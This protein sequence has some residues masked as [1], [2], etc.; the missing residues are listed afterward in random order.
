M[1]R[2]LVIFLLFLAA[3][4]VTRAQG[5]PQTTV[6]VDVDLVQVFATVTDEFN[7][8]VVG[9]EPRNFELFEDKVAQK[10]ETFSSEDVPLSVGII[11]D[12]SGSMK[13]NL[14]LAKDAAVTFLKLGNPEDEYFLVEFSDRAQVTEDFTSDISKLQNHIA[15]TPSKGM[16]ALFD[17]LYLG[18]NRV[19]GGSN[20]RKFLLV[21]T[22]GGENHSHYSFGQ[23]R[24]FA[25]EQDV[26]LYWIQ[27]AGGGGIPTSGTVGDIV[28]MTGGRRFFARSPF[29][30]EDICTK[31]AI[32]VK[33]QYVIGYRS[34]N[35]NRDGKYRHIRMKVNPPKG[36]AQLFIR[37][38]EGYFAP[39]N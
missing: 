23:V 32:E 24:D 19:R 8:Y 33:N 39:G 27:I 35:G 18:L 31:I 4:L 34:S 2:L 38:K 10:I 14:V 1:R 30:L 15:F 17:A 5:R 6:K 26:Q 9:L 29:D 13:P 22:D 28:E 12:V 7:H 21:I 25:R 20:P 11:L 3:T 16:T 36:M 37:A